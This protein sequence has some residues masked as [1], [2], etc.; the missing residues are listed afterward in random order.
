MTSVFNK[1]LDISSE[2]TLYKLQTNIYSEWNL[3]LSP[4]YKKEDSKTNDNSYPI[5]CTRRISR[6]TFTVYAPSKKTGKQNN[7]KPK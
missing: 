3:N 6:K 4:F 1:L 5:S 7:P 2:M